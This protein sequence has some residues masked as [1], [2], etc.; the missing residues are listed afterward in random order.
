MQLKCLLSHVSWRRYKKNKIFDSLIQIFMRILNFDLR[1]NY[2][3]KYRSLEIIHP[4]LELVEFVVSWINYLFSHS[5]VSI[6]VGVIWYSQKGPFD[7]LMDLCFDHK[8]WCFCKQKIL[9]FGS[10][11]LLLVILLVQQKPTYVYFLETVNLD[12]SSKIL[13]KKKNSFE[14]L[15]FLIP[16]PTKKTFFT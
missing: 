14:Y 4:F 8:I 7:P 16:M 2:V 12:E 6:S 10:F 5:K 11:S 9:G 3:F 13:K 1:K 15:I